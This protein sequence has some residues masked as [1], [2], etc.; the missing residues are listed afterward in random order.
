[1]TWRD[2]DRESF[3]ENK[4]SEESVNLFL[5]AGAVQDKDNGHFSLLGLFILAFIVFFSITYFLSPAM[6]YK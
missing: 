1:M 4:E 2:G 5:L 3:D 6:I